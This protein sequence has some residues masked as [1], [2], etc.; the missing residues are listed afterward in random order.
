MH[1][2]VIQPLKSHPRR[3]LLIGLLSV[4]LIVN[5]DF[6]SLLSKVFNR[7]KPIVSPLTETNTLNDP[8][9]LHY[10]Q[11]NTAKMEDARNSVPA[12]FSGKLEYPAWMAN[13]P[14]GPK[15]PQVN[16]LEGQGLSYNTPQD[17]SRVRDVQF[18]QPQGITPQEQPGL[19]FDS[20]MNKMKA[21][22]GVQQANASEM[23]TPT[24][25]PTPHPLQGA[26]EKA[27]NEYRGGVPIATMAAQ[28]AQA[29]EGLPDPLMPAIMPLI[30]TAGGEAIT[31]GNNNL[32]NMLPTEAGVNYPDY[33]TAILGGGPDEQKG[34]VGTIKGGKYDDYLESGDLA[35]FFDTFSPSHEN[36]AIA[37]QITRYNSIRKQYF[38][39]YLP[40]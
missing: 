12:S 7:Q 32:Y 26:I 6:N 16:P 15:V 1:F 4:I 17:K 27:L 28:L 36:A 25:T 3:I 39:P 5:M 40:R 14:Q 9:K 10:V 33:E 18:G 30:E 29:G 8:G 38:E 21:V 19:S 23:P 37:D 24:P 13:A 11:Q 31:R 35:D 2:S 22:L 20:L 34:F